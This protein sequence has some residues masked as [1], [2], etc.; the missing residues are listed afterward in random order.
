MTERLGLAEEV[1]KQ[2]VSFDDRTVLLETD[3]NRLIRALLYRV[4]E[5]SD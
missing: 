3:N 5:S 1:S 2:V 4:F